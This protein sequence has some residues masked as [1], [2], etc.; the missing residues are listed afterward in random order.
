MGFDFEGE[1]LKECPIF[2]ASE[3]TWSVIRLYSHYKNGYLP[4]AGGINDQT[5]QFLR[6]MEIIDSMI[7]EHQREKPNDKNR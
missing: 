1:D 7:L 6:S 4:I 3:N 2:L 5:P